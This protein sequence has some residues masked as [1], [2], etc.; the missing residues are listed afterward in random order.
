[1]DTSISS[2]Q[3]G[4][5]K[6]KHGNTYTEVAGFNITNPGKVASGEFIDVVFGRDALQAR[7][8]EAVFAVLV[9]VRKV[10]YTDTGVDMVVAAVKGVLATFV[11]SGFL[12]A[13]PAPVVVAPK[14]KDVAQS[15]R[16]NRLLPDV[17]FSATLAGAIQA[18]EISGRI[19]V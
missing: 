13:D 8:Q 6:G 11:T 14:V 10:P 12:A 18:V 2:T 1:V 3:E 15:D 7:I 9:S 5:V 17:D 16:A 4:V 19:S